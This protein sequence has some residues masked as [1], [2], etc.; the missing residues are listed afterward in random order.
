M[1]NMWNEKKRYIYINK[2]YF[3]RVLKKNFIFFQKYPYFYKIYKAK[4][5]T[6]WKRRNRNLFYSKEEGKKYFY[7]IYKMKSIISKKI[8]LEMKKDVTFK[9]KGKK[10]YKS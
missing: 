4:N 5:I 3:S 7:K 1:Y 9:K 8:F 2:N 10:F 6:I